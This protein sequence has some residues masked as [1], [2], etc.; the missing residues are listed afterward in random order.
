MF[1]NYAGYYNN[2]TWVPVEQKKR[3]PTPLNPLAEFMIPLIQ[4][5]CMQETHNLFKSLI[6]DHK[7]KLVFNDAKQHGY[8]YIDR[9]SD[10][11]VVAHA[12]SV[13][14]KRFFKREQNGG[15]VIYSPSLD[16]R[17]G[18]AIVIDILPL[19]GITADVLI[20]DE[21]ECGNSSAESFTTDKK[22]KWI[23]EF[24]RMLGD[25]VT[26]SY[27][28]AEW[29]S[30]IAKHFGRSGWGIYSDICEMESLGCCAVN[31]GVGYENYH[32]ISAWADLNITYGNLVKFIEFY[33][34]FKDK[35]FEHTKRAWG[36]F[37]GGY[38]RGYYPYGDWGDWD[39]KY[40]PNT[41]RAGEWYSDTARVYDDWSN[42]VVTF[43]Q[44]KETR[45]RY[46]GSDWKDYT[47]KPQEY[48]PK[49][50]A[51]A[52]QEHLLCSRCSSI[53]TET[54]TMMADMTHI[55]CPHCGSV[56]DRRHA[57]DLF[58]TSDNFF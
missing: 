54:E 43:K 44:F 29:E 11:L 40:V 8:V 53:F 38:D 7:G 51:I 15:S 2:G 58:Y 31:I 52:V 9:G 26:Y 57:E 12:D 6:K 13:Q 48:D 22:Y 30:A 36:S 24:D 37:G 50:H 32:S 20:T 17:L 49:K 4:R 55:Y 19:L 42:E 27:T 28:E 33:K 47:D 10:I 3:E 46:C 14:Q 23:A 35:H 41:E 5:R 39:D 21:E 18:C 56:C 1:N 34:E 16:D 25:V 45:A